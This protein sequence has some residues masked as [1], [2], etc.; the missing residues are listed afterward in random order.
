M[1][2]VCSVKDFKINILPYL[3]KMVEWYDIIVSKRGGEATIT[4]LNNI[5]DEIN[6]NFK[7]ELCTTE[8]FPFDLRSTSFEVKVIVPREESR[9]AGRIKW[10]IENYAVAHEFIEIL[11]KN[12]CFYTIGLSVD[13]TGK[14]LLMMNDFAYT[15]CGLRYKACAETIQSGTK[16]LI[17]ISDAMK[18]LGV[19]QTIVN[20]IQECNLV[21]HNMEGVRGDPKNKYKPKVHGR[22]QNPL[23]KTIEGGFLNMHHIKILRDVISHSTEDLKYRSFEPTPTLT[24]V[25]HS[26][27]YDL[28]GAL[29]FRNGAVSSIMKYVVPSKVNGTLCLKDNSMNCR[30]FA[31]DFYLNAE[32]LY[33]NLQLIFLTDPTHVPMTSCKMPPPTFLDEIQ[34]NPNPRSSNQEV[35]LDGRG[36][37]PPQ[38]RN[39][40]SR[41]S[42]S[43]NRLSCLSQS[44]NRRSKQEDGGGRYG[45]SEHKKEH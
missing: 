21:C 20:N 38:S 31:E 45:G 10:A 26:A 22:I 2:D 30:T 18:S 35:G 7:K 17:P 33:T 5:Y 12:G 13:E 36:N 14:P 6:T 27:E 8:D 41:L 11:G 37:N 43:K 44:K 24:A 16:Y 32:Q 15:L 25:L 28:F 39:R 42:Q 23:S 34:P 3:D 29:K 19:K 9:T 1:T 4:D 40:R